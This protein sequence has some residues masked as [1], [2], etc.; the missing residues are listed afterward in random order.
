MLLYDPSGLWHFQGLMERSEKML[1][2]HE[3]GLIRYQILVDLFE[4]RN[5]KTRDRKKNH[6]FWL[7]QRNQQ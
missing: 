7:S 6:G 3:L 5:D 1:D 2:I 4:L